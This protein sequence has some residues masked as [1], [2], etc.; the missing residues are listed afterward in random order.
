[1]VHLDASLHDS[2]FAA[3]GRT[4]GA[5]GPSCSRA[6]RCGGACSHRDHDGLKSLGGHRESVLLQGRNVGRD[7]FA[8]V[9]DGFFLRLA[10]AHASWDAGVGHRGYRGGGTCLLPHAGHASRRETEDQSRKCPATDLPTP[11]EPPHPGPAARRAAAPPAGR[12]EE[13]ALDRHRLDRVARQ[14]AHAPRI[15]DRGASGN[16][17]EGLGL[18]E[19]LA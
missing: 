9:G 1:M 6:R 5:P 8:D 17:C 10:L 13:E 18:S 14:P 12:E 4:L 11:R 7:R 15:C 19:T 16:P 3:C 2:H